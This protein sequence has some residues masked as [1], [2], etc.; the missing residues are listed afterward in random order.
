MLL[1][2]PGQFSVL[3]NR[4][5]REKEISVLISSPQTLILPWRVCLRVWQKAGA[6]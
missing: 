4:E 2:K 6:L 5:K 3:Q 1:K